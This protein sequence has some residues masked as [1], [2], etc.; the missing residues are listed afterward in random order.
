LLQGVGIL[1]ATVGLLGPHLLMWWALCWGWAL[2]QPSLSTAVGAVCSPQR[3]GVRSF[4]PP[5]PNAVGLFH[6]APRAV[7]TAVCTARW[8]V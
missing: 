3:R 8:L 2:M 6:R 4:P 7:R 5:R 1:Y